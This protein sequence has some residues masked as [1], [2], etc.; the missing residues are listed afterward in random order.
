MA[1]VPDAEEIGRDSFSSDGL[2]AV[3]MANCIDACLISVGRGDQ[4]GNTFA[5]Y[6]LLQ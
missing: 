3:N 4:S 2:T 1:A 6:Q 5:N